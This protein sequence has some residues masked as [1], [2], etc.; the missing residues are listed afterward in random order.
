MQW[1][2]ERGE[3]INK[4]GSPDSQCCSE[5][6]NK[7]EAQT[8]GDISSGTKRSSEEEEAARAELWGKRIPAGGAPVLR[9]REQPRVVKE[10]RKRQCGCNVAKRESNGGRERPRWVVTRVCCI[11]M[12]MGSH[13][14]ILGRGT[15]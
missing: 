4:R 9:S 2:V 10:Q 14:R 11:L 5:E 3:T 6:N 1:R 12:A 8:D 15:T 7:T 13:H